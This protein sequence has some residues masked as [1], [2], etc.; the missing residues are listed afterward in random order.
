MIAKSSWA[1]WHASGT[2]ILTEE[3]HFVTDARSAECAAQI[4]ARWNSAPV[5]LQFILDVLPVLS[6]ESEERMTLGNDEDR[7]NLESL[8]GRIGAILQLAKAVG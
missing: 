2:L 8:I 1:K 4:C 5:M 7:A 3:D 6:Q